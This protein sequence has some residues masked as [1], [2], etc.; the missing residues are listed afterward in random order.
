MLEYYYLYKWV[1]HNQKD[2]FYGKR[3]SLFHL[4]PNT[5]I[6]P[7]VKASAQT[8]RT[9]LN[10]K[11]RKFMFPIFMLSLPHLLKPKGCSQLVT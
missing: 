4:S 6:L 2:N 7:Q 9:S 11:M 5:K 3:S 10:F 8:S 1:K